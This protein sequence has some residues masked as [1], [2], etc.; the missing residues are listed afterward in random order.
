MLSYFKINPSRS[1]KLARL[2][3]VK[4]FYILRNLKTYQD[5]ANISLSNK[6]NLLK[7]KWN[8]WE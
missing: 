1:H 8:K 4:Q 6:W 2:L 5:T 3:L 7:L